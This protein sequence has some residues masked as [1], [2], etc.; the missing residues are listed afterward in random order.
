MDAMLLDPQDVIVDWECSS[1]H[2][3]A[4]IRVAHPA[5]H[6]QATQDVARIFFHC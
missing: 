6:G 4:E 1:T 5:V 2:L 3:H